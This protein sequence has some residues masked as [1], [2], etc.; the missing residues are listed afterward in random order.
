[1]K[2]RRMTLEDDFK[3]E[4]IGH[5][6]MA[7]KKAFF[8][9]L[10]NYFTHPRIIRFTLKYCG[11]PIIK[12][13]LR[14][15]GGWKSM[16]AAY[17]RRK[18]GGP[19]DYLVQKLASLPMGLRNRKRM[20]VRC[21]S[22]LLNNSKGPVNLVSVGAGPGI[23]ELEAMARST[24]QS[25]HCYFLDL[26]SEAF[27]YGR[28][29]ARG[30]GLLDRVS[31]IQGNVVQIRDLIGIR[32]D[33]VTTI[34]ILEYLTDEQISDILEA[35]YE[36]MPEGGCVLSSS[37]TPR[38]GTDRFLRKILKLRLN[39]RNTESVMHLLGCVGYN[40]FEVEYEPLGIYSIV[41]G[42]KHSG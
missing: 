30:L 11:S 14:D 1:M 22:H 36:I 41:T 40:H 24:N 8:N 37:I 34:G 12:A 3:L 15:P 16:I 20:A 28:L 38:H 29:V 35:M 5:L 10:I 18:P 27:E 9:P 25:V 7:F 4:S 13:S 39:Y 32:P 17:A 6:R 19:V 23:N 31:F 26:A 42:H 21:L 2:E 33:I